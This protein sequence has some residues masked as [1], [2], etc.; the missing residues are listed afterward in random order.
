MP[1]S[2]SKSRYDSH[3][4]V[5][6]IRGAIQVES[7]TEEAISQGSKELLTRILQVNEL[8]PQ[9]I[10]SVIFTATADLNATFPARAARELG[11]ELV[12]LLCAVEIDVPGA[13][14][15]TIRA[16]IHCNSSRSPEQ[17]EHVYLGGASVLRQDLAQ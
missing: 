14:A 15:R 9:E 5:R 13:L 3:M 2:Y 4:T 10:I 8:A 1:H 12:P 16:L 6:A 7:N 11:F 17:I